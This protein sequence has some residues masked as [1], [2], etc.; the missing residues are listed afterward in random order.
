M[1]NTVIII[2]R[3]WGKKPCLYD[4]KLICGEITF[5]VYPKTQDFPNYNDNSSVGHVDWKQK[6]EGKTERKKEESI[7][8]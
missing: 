7:Q 1:Q 6:Q 5:S 4:H 3:A 8:P 2:A